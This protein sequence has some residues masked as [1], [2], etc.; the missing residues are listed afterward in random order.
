MALF[1]SVLVL[2]GCTESPQDELIKGVSSARTAFEEP[3]PEANKANGD[4]ALYVP[5][6]Y[7]LQEPSDDYNLLLTRGNE[8]FALFLNPNEAPD[9]TFFYD[10][11]KAIPEEAWLVDEK[12]SQHG[13]FGFTTVREIADE[14]YELVVSSGGTKLSTITEQSALRTNMD[15]M[16]ETVRSV[17]SAQGE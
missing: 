4:T 8:A 2:A 12:F 6:G 13:R 1:S 10:L 11:Q 14:R 17:E 16:M 3:A 9:S 5:G 7:E 15:W